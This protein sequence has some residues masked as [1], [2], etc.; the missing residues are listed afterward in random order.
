MTNIIHLAVAAVAEL[1]APASSSTHAQ[2]RSMKLAD[3]AAE[4][5]RYVVL[6]EAAEGRKP[7][8]SHLFGAAAA[9]HRSPGRPWGARDGPRVTPDSFVRYRGDA[10]VIA[11]TVF[12][13]AAREARPSRRGRGDP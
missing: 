2:A 12:G 1:W 10:E 5:T 3:V 13:P 9:I 7:P 8:Y 4:V 6:Y 11:R